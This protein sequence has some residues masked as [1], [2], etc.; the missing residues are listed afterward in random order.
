MRRVVLD[1]SVL[2]AGLRSRRGASFVLLRAVR[3]GVIVPLCTPSLF[4]EYDDVLHR[5]EQIEATG[6]TA[7]EMDAVLGA[8]ASVIE[9]VE[10]HILWRPQ[11]SDADDE[12]VLEAAVNGRAE[13]LVTHNVGD[14]AEAAPRFGLPV[15]RPGEMLGHALLRR[16]TA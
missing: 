7:T 15:L 8:L 9:P 1:T 6:L 12:L 2:V 5:A 16:F 10:V 11:L 3:E 4:L 13:A 14:F